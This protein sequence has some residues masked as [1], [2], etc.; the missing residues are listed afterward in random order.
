MMIEADAAT[1]LAAH[2]WAGTTPEPLAG[3]ASARRYFRLRKAGA[4]AILM[5]DGDA[6]N[7][8]AFLAVADWLAALGLS[9]PQILGH[10][11]APG[12]I[13]LEDL[14][15]A[16]FGR[17]VAR[18]PTLQIPLHEAATDLLADLH[19]A[20]PP[21]WL[22]PYDTAKLGD[23]VRVTAETYLPAFAAPLPTAAD[24]LQ[25][26]VISA[27]RRLLDGPPVVCLRDFHAENLIWLPD[28]KGTAR[29]GLLDFQDAFTGDPAYDLVS[30]LQ[31]AR[32]DVDPALEAA[33]IA[34]FCAATGHDP[35]RFAA[36]YALLGAQRNIRILGVLTRLALQAGKRQYLPLLPR[37][38]GHVTRN[39]GHPALTELAE[40]VARTLPPP[41]PARLAELMR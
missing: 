37:V 38:W 13:L 10:D 23:L 30:L 22:A 9:A 31:D 21:A 24:L 15:D 34:R 3:D 19:R 11:P 25:D 20:P 36:A 29:V 33:M 6:A 7:R 28:R 17:E 41:D 32:R 35:A 18:A 40:V 5:Q 1:L 4:S 2:G 16:L 14:G 27:A 26:A 39:L 12:L 8:A